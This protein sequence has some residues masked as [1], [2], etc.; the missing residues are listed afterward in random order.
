M[1]DIANKL[2]CLKLN[3][4]W[5]VIDQTL[6]CDALVDLAGGINSYALDIEYAVKENGE[7][8]FSTPVVTR[9]VGWDEWITLPIRSWDFSIR[10]VKLKIRIPTILIAKNY[11]GMPHLKFKDIPSTE[12]VRI[13]DRDI[14]QYTGRKLSKHEISLDHVI[15]VSKGGKNTWENLVITSKEINSKKGNR[16]NHELG[17]KLIRKPVKPLPIPRYNLILE[18][19][20]KDWELFIKK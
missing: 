19:R 13:R 12:Q 1:D 7:V 14:C 20:H 2:L 10:S 11:E 6:V 9:P 5:Q 16:F 8:D 3:K 18:A 17:L 15:P 4:H